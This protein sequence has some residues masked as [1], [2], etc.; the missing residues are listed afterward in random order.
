MI[1][2]T[3]WAFCRLLQVLSWDVL[4]HILRE[5]PARRIVCF[6]TVKMHEQVLWSFARIKS[7]L[8]KNFGFVSGHSV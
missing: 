7:N 6:I 2:P 3:L 1:S 8:L 5:A 4:L